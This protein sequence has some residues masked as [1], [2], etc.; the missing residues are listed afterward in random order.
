M[1]ARHVR[2]AF[3]S[4]LHLGSR[5]C[6]AEMVLQFLRAHRFERLFLVGDIVDGLK[7]GRGWHWP[8]TH[9]EV[10]REFLRLARGGTEVI[11]LPG[12][13]DPALRALPGL[14]IGGI[15]VADTYVH[16]LA[17]GRK[18]LVQHGDQFDSVVVFSRW[19]T[20]LG[21]WAYDRLIAMNGTVNRVRGWFGR[22]YWSLSSYLKLKVKKVMS[23]VSSF[24][25]W[26][27]AEAR[28]RGVDGVV[29]GHIHKAEI[30]TIGDLLYCNTG[31]W[32]ESCTALLEDHDGRLELVEWSRVTAAAPVP[33]EA[34]A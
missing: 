26:L 17:D 8:E 1:H 11:Y 2:T 20:R 27:V 22:P 4:D 28:E 9:T 6:Q 7:L 34:V 19:L 10:V 24:E 15:V 13:H 23:Y 29:C 32:V 14:A 25:E 12:N 5:G 3:I 30:R 16:E 18:L 33:S 31:D 21:D